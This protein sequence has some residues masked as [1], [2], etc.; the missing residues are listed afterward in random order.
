MFVGV[1]LSGRVSPRKKPRK[2][3]RD[4]PRSDDKGEGSHTEG[5][6]GAEVVVLACYLA[7]QRRGRQAKAHRKAIQVRG[8]GEFRCACLLFN[9]VLRLS[10]GYAATKGNE[11]QSGGG[12]L[13]HP[14]GPMAEPG[15]ASSPPDEGFKLPNYEH[16]ALKIDGRLFYKPLWDLDTLTE[17]DRAAVEYLRSLPGPLPMAR[18]REQYYETNVQDENEGLTAEE[19]TAKDKKRHGDFLLQCFAQGLDNGESKP[20]LFTMPPPEN[21][22]LLRPAAPGP[23]IKSEDDELLMSGGPDTG[24]ADG[25]AE[26]VP[27][28]DKDDEIDDYYNDYSGEP[29]FQHGGHVG[30]LRIHKSG[31]AILDWGGMEMELFKGGEIGGTLSY[32]VI[33]D[34]ENRDPKSGNTGRAVGMGQL[35]GTIGVCTL[36]QRTDEDWIDRMAVDQETLEKMVKEAAAKTG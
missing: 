35:L 18:R 22:P 3:P 5:G 23:R 10:L 27:A 19:R 28:M 16:S 2:S 11:N 24:A 34:D 33:E 21:L 15:S 29:K 12:S 17:E 9:G 32:M 6:G 30:K 4:W 8:F 13:S 20:F 14:S 26:A 31:K 25:Q 7:G 36:D 1:R